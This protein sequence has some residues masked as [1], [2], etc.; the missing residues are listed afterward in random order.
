ML[1]L[2]RPLQI[3][4]FIGMLATGARGKYRCAHAQHCAVCRIDM[5]NK[6]KCLLLSSTPWHQQHA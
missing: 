2:V 4:K 6:M 3:T 5:H 1:R